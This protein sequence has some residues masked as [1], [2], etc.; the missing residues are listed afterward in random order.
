M[1]PDELTPIRLGLR[2]GAVA[3][4]GIDYRSVGSFEPYREFAVIV[5]V[6]SAGVGG[7]PT[8]LAG[9]GGYVVDLPVTT[10]PSRALG[11]EIWGFPKSVTDIET[12]MTPTRMRARVD[13][14]GRRDVDFRV[15]VQNAT[16]RRARERLTA[17]THLDDHLTRVPVDLDAVIRVA[18]G[19]DGVRLARGKGRYAALLDDLALSPQVDAR[20]VAS[21]VTATIHPPEPAE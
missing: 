18:G 8:S 14:D 17:F 1:L 3:L 10:E 7:I 16:A 20:F 11:E 13:A 21:D 9:V 19:G 6:A 12:E 15:D 2:R 4:V 5:P